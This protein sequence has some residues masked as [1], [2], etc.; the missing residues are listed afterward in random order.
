MRVRRQLAPLRRHP[1]IG[2]DGLAFTLIALR[3]LLL[4]MPPLLA[5][6]VAVLAI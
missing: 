1:A 3:S 6:C 4:V 2:T 5:A